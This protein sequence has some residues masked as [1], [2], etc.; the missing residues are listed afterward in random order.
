MV[1]GLDGE[2][3]V[4]HPALCQTVHILQSAAGA[5]DKSDWCGLLVW[6]QFPVV[7]GVLGEAL[8]LRPAG[9]TLG[10][11]RPLQ[12][13]AQAGPTD[14]PLQLAFMCPFNEETAGLAA[15]YKAQAN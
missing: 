8:W 7:S 12:T 3:G 6:T 4:V 13:S 10:R 14:A 11:P 1:T 2:D 15:C 5:A 9:S